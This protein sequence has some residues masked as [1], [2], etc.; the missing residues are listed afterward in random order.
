LESRL[1]GA[2]DRLLIIQGVPCGVAANHIRAMEGGLDQEGLQEHL[3][4][5]I[6]DPPS[7]D[8][9]PWE[10][11]VRHRSDKRHRQQSSAPAPRHGVFPAHTS[12]CECFYVPGPTLAFQCPHALMMTVD[13]HDSSRPS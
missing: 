6:N 12:L 7:L 3:A 1:A 11:L 4:N 5:I 2:S 13:P 10:L 9:P 8:H